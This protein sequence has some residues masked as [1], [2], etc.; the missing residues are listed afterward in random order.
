M[1]VSDGSE[2]LYFWDVENFETQRKVEVTRFD[3]SIQTQINELE[4]MDGLVCY[5]IWHEDD[6]I[7]AD[8]ETGKSV[9][10]YGKWS[11]T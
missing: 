3:G 9:R 10:E 5:N 7:C 6:I 8:P 11:D 1:I 4:F 2:F